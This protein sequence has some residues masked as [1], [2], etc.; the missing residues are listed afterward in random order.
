MSR[1]H[2]ISRRRVIAGAVAGLIAVAGCAQL[3]PSAV[4]PIGP[5]G[6][7]VARSPALVDLSTSG[8][9]AMSDAVDAQPVRQAGQARPP[10][11]PTG[12]RTLTVQRGPIAD[13][14][15]LTGR[16]A[17]VNELPLSFSVRGTVDV[18]NVRPGDRV[19]A[20]QV[21][22][23]ADSKSVAKERAAA[24]GERD[25]AVLRLQRGLAAVDSRSHQ[26]QLERRAAES[27][28]LVA[29]SNR[30]KA[31]AEL[32]RLTAPPTDEQMKEARQRVAGAELTLQAA[33]AD[34]AKLKSGPDPIAV[35]TAQKSLTDAL[36]TQLA[37]QKEYSR[38]ADGPDPFDLRAA[39]R[40]VEQAR[41]NLSVAQ[42]SDPEKSGV[43]RDTAVASAQL[44]LEAAKD[45]LKQL[46]QP[47]SA[48]QI[49]VA[50]QRVTDSQA[51]VAAAQKQLEMAKKGPDKLS[52]DR[53]KVAADSARFA[54]TSAQTILDRLQAGASEDEVRLARTAVDAAQLALDSAQGRF[55][56][57]GT[58]ADDQ[59]IGLLNK[60]VADA[61]ERV[62]DLQA[63]LD[64][65]QLRAPSAGIVAQLSVQPGDPIVPNMPVAVL[66]SSSDP[67]VRADLLDAGKAPRVAVGQKA[68][69]Q[70]DGV[71]GDPLTGTVISVVDAA[72]PGNHVALIQ[73]SWGTM[74]PAVG[75]SARV[76]VTVQQRDAALV[77]P[78]RALHN[79]G[80]VQYVEVIENGVRKNVNVEVGIIS[81]SQV[82]ITNGLGEGMEVVVPG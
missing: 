19:Q 81:S 22:M 14:L 48:D 37:A 21:L 5:Q 17:G 71:G 31:E 13:V 72:T 49:A 25:A 76:S 27:A 65:M 32:N 39:Q 33:E 36:A 69:V 29:R 73:V 12:V 45:R 42:S 77:V 3:V 30:E 58:G 40:A 7:Q 52:I 62:A 75:T 74:R 26:T 35:L 60:A 8:P 47:A 28:V 20:G 50:R 67:V 38:L 68:S 61:R 56:F 24:Q 63:T 11:L 2:V 1:I 59:D 55:G 43:P 4:P 16:I 66:S 64:A 34:L 80:S 70:I 44:G 51:G 23:E 10:L 53:A 78:Q 6:N 41:L 46:Q 79:A 9:P 82:E 18:V 57:V 15:L 54:L